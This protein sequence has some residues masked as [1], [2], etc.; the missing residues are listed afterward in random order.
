[1]AFSG[2]RGARFGRD[3]LGRR[4]GFDGWWGGAWGSDGPY[5]D[6]GYSVSDSYGYAEPYASGYW[7]YCQNPP[8]YYPYVQQCR[9]SWQPMPAG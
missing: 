6:Y 4:D 7:Y 3:G 9:V 5:Y 8:G 1:M 2:F